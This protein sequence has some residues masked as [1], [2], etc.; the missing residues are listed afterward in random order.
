LA[1]A[2]AA[3]I[4]ALNAGSLARCSDIHDRDTFARS[5]ASVWLPVALSAAKKAALRAGL[6][7][8]LTA[9]SSQR[10]LGSHLIFLLTSNRLHFREQKEAIHICH[11]GG[12][13]K[14]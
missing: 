11:S 8:A 4:S 10:R 7:L 5:Q 13:R 12:C 1:S 3:A 2:T 9:P 6:V 14:A